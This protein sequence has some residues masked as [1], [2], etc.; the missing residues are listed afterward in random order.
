MIFFNMASINKKKKARNSYCHGSL[1][2]KDM[3][4]KRVLFFNLC[5]RKKFK[6]D[7]NSQEIEQKVSS[8]FNSGKKYGITYTPSFFINGTLIDNPPS[9]EEFAKLIE[10]AR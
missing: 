6:N 3:K 9:Y 1:K 5:V 2:E 8:D 4:M 10:S 7:L